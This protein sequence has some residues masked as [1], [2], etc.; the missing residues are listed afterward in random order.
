MTGTTPTGRVIGIDLG[1]TNTLA[2]YADGRVSRVIPTER[3]G[4]LLPSVVAFAG[5]R[6][7]VGQPAKDQLLI[8]PAETISGSKRLVGRP[9]HSPQI[10]KL[11]RRLA[12]EVVEGADGFCA[13]RAGG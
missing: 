4:N 3:G 11:K 5:T 6:V 12:Y 13:V 10:Q 8:H 2:A 9:F 7:L 1:T